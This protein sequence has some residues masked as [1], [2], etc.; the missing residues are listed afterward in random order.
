MTKSSNCP[1]WFTLFFR[2]RPIIANRYVGLF[3]VW[4]FVW[5]ALFR[6]RTIY[7]ERRSA[8]KKISSVKELV[9]W[10]NKYYKYKAD[11]VSGAIDHDNSEYEFFTTNGDCDD[12]A[13]YAKIKLRQLGY[14]ANRVMMMDTSKGMVSSHFDCIFK[15]DDGYGIFDYGKPKY[16]NSIQECMD[17]LCKSW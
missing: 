6:N 17:I 14:K 7:K 13:L 8:W 4:F 12:I 15:T 9:D 11:M 16:G 5:F 1:W 2:I 10:C 3:G